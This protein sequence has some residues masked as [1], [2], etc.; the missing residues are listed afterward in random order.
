MIVYTP[1]P[2]PKIRMSRKC[3]YCKNTEHNA[4]ICTSPLLLNCLAELCQH[5]N[6]LV[7]T[8]PNKSMPRDEAVSY[9]SNL[10]M[11]YIYRPDYNNTLNVLVRNLRLSER[12]TPHA[13]SCFLITNYIVERTQRNNMELP[14]ING[15]IRGVL[16][17]VEELVMINRIPNGFESLEL[18]DYRDFM[19][20][21]DYL[22]SLLDIM[23]QHFIPLEIEHVVMMETEVL[24]DCPICLTTITSLNKVT[25]DCNHNYCNPCFE[26]MVQHGREISSITCALC[27]K[28]ISKCYKPII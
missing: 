26:R 5:F 24:E 13:T 27:R 23:F 17:T 11:K 7:S 9:A 4:S 3:S 1:H 28:N 22:K 19:L 25:T 20:N 16:V 21:N 6:Y 10:F 18:A 15:I 2:H 12:M 8:I 14:I